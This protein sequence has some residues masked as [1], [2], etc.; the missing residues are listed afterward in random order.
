MDLIASDS[1]LLLLPKGIDPKQRLFPDSIR[2]SAHFVGVAY[3]CLIENLEKSSPR[4]VR[5]KDCGLKA[6][7]YAWSVVD[8]V[9]RLRK[10][11]QRMPRYRDRMPSK[12]VFL[13]STSGAEDLRNAIQHLDTEIETL[14]KEGRPP[15]GALTWIVPI[16]KSEGTMRI[17]SFIPSQLEGAN[18]GSLV[19]VPSEV[20]DH[21][22]QVELWASKYRINLSELYRAV[23]KLVSSLETFLRRQRPELPCDPA[24]TWV[25]MT[26]Q[27]APA[28]DKETG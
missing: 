19:S 14:L 11:V 7:L 9:Y 5:E 15:M 28:E 12:Q 22:D 6:I 3:K 20:P 24:D 25:S 1:P 21:I 16:D 8:S 10:L 23:A 26:V 18:P 27:M 17:E 2:V 4:E 13:R